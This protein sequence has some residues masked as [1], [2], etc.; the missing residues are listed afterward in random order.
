MMRASTGEAV[1]KNM[2]EPRDVRV[3]AIFFLLLSL[4]LSLS[5]FSLNT[6]NR[7]L[8]VET[9]GIGAKTI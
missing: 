4:S 5:L 9:R 2:D 8:S 1:E 6:Y 3:G 7:Y